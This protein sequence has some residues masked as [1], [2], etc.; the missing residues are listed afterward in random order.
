MH[1]QPVNETSTRFL[2]HLDLDRSGNNL[3][4]NIWDS[5]FQFYTLSCYANSAKVLNTSSSI[6]LNICEARWPNLYTIMAP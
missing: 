1:S 3:L 5:M 2:R 4:P 6:G